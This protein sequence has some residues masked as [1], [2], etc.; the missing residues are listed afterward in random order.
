[1]RAV[2]AS[3]LLLPLLACQARTRPYL[4]LA[5]LESEGEV[6]VYL[7]PFAAGAEKLSFSIQSVAAVRSDGTSVPLEVML[8]DVSRETAPRQRLLAFGRL[9]PDAYAALAIQVGRAA[10]LTP[11]G[12]ADLHLTKEP[13]RI[14]V[15]FQIARRRSTVLSLS[16]QVDQAVSASYGFTPAFAA[17]LSPV[18]VTQ[19]TGYA[20]SPGSAALAVFDK[21]RQDVVAVLPTGREPHG[22]VLDQVQLRAYVALTGDDQVQI[23]DLTGGEEIG[24]ISLQPGDRPRELALTPDGRTLVATNPGSRTVSILDPGSRLERDR[25]RVG[26]DPDALVLDRTGQRLFVLNRRSATVSVLDLGTRQAV[27]TIPTDPEPIAGQLNRAG[28]RLYV[29]HAGSAYLNVYSLPDLGLSTRIYVGLGATALKVDPRTD[30]VYVGRNEGRLDVYDPSAFI[31]VD[32]IDLP[33]VPSYLVIDD[34]ENALLAL[35]PEARQAAVV[36]LTRR[37]VVGQIDLLPGPHE[38]AVT[39]ERY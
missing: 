39:G 2:V 14:P 19:L 31:P 18:P 26:E 15:G 27:G 28:T 20:S 30:L 9:P 1:M 35:V 17:T 23:L 10:L 11:D 38:L 12:K 4:V 36:D 13:A 32:R 33:G 34:R 6:Y 22:V 16:L 5:P 3:A 37:R 21:R 29:A 25:V 7:Q 8:A 24:R